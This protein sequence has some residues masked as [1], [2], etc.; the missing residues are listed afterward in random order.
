[1]SSASLLLAAALLGSVIGQGSVMQVEQE[2]LPFLT[3]GSTGVT[4]TSPAG[5]LKHIQTLRLESP[6]STPFSFTSILVNGA[7][8]ELLAVSPLTASAIESSAFVT[9]GLQPTILD[10]YNISQAT[11]DPMLDADGQPIFLDD[12]L[13]VAVDGRY[14][15]R[16][17]GDLTVAYARERIFIEVLRFRRGV[18]SASTI[19]DVP[20]AL[21]DFCGESTSLPLA[22]ISYLNRLRGFRDDLLAL[23]SGGFRNFSKPRGLLYAAG[24]FNVRDGIRRFFVESTGGYQPS[25]VAQL[26]NGDIMI[27]F[28]QDGDIEVEGQGLRIGYV[29]ADELKEGILSGG[30]LNPLIIAD[31]LRNDG[32]N[33][34]VQS[35]LAVREDINGRI[36]VYSMSDDFLE[37]S[38]T[39]LT[40]FEWKPKRRRHRR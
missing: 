18:E 32:F 35:G 7:G 29:T 26:R 25:A 39:L 13:S 6:D 17:R 9:L 19:Q 8:S 1:M 3:N 27:A 12:A 4:F 14:C 15:G 10:R 40:T 30:T 28:V 20:V 24:V 22:A 37:P 16:G 23:C 5:Q 38:Q 34:A 21:F 11:V 36:F 2:S 33:I 31:L